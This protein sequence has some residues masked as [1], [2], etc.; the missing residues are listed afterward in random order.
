[1]SRFRYVL[2]A[3][4]ALILVGL[5]LVFIVRSRV[6]SDRVSCQDH[7][8]A[9]G[10]MGVRHAST[11][12]QAIPAR[13]RDELPPGTFENPGLRPEQRMSWYVYTLNVLDQGVPEPDVPGKHRRP[14]GLADRLTKFDPL[15]S[16][17]AHTNGDLASY[18][19]AAAVCPGQV[20]E[21][22]PGSPVLTNYVALGGLGLDTPA[23][24]LDQAGPNA[25]AYR[26]DGPTSNALF[27]DGLR[28]T[29]QILETTLALGPW[30]QGGPSTLRGLDPAA[31]PYLG[32]NRPF[33]GCHPGG[34]FMS[35]AD[36][37]VQFVKDTVQPA[38]F[39]SMFTLAGG[40][41]EQNFDVP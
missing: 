11:P 12:G 15:G 38:V 34:A 9:L 14:A 6:A 4:A 36:G 27:R 37:S 19:L 25:G 5:A 21:F 33:G 8:R 17:D 35:M 30:L 7:L 22:T 18:R 28:Q 20:P 39:R 24:P 32:P 1:V 29:A 26:Y 40:P 3:V 2:F 16:W 23:K 13:R 31:I 10:L 41:D